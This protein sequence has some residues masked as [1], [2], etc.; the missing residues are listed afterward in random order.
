M[1]EIAGKHCTLIESLT[2]KKNKFPKSEQSRGRI[3]TSQPERWYGKEAVLSW[4]AKHKINELGQG[5]TLNKKK[6]NLSDNKPTNNN[7]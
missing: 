3:D 6:A 4:R 7:K 5:K 2:Q 1:R